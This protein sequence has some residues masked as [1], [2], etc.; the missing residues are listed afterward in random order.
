MTGNDYSTVLFLSFLSF[1]TTGLGALLAL[2]L[3]RNDQA[4]ATGIGFSSGIMLLLS[5][6]ELIPEASETA[7]LRLT[8]F[9]VAS[10]ALLLWLMH[11]ILPHSHLMKEHGLMGGTALK[12]VYLVVIGLILHDI[13]EGFA[14]ANAYMSTP[15][16]GVLVAVGIALH[17]L[18]EEF[19]LCMPVITLKNNRLLITIALL[20]ALAEPLGALAGLLAIDTDP[21]L[22]PVFLAFASGAMIFVSVHELIP[23]ARRYGSGWHLCAGFM[24]SWIVYRLLAEAIAGHMNV[25]VQ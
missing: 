16:L 13:P 21:A 8:L 10:G 7:G 2:F 25:P 22:I 5:F 15:S 6:A 4:V 18:P 12:S 23:L 24:L 9:T 20:S 3:G 14:M 19:A 1:L 11:K 17:N